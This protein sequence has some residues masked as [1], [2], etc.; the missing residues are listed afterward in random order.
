MN[1]V[2]NNSY[3]ITNVNIIPMNQDTVLVD[4]MVYIKEGIIEKIADTIEVKGIEIFDAEEQ[5][6]HTRPYRYACACLG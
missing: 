6:S 4:K 3:L 1:Q 2:S 5:V